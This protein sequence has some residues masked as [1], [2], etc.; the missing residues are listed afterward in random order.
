M[1]ALLLSV[2][3]A[4]ATQVWEEKVEEGGELPGHEATAEGEV[5]EA[6][7]ATTA[8]ESV[9]ELTESFDGPE[10]VETGD[11]MMTKTEAANLL[12]SNFESTNGRVPTEEDLNAVA[13]S[14]VRTNRR[15]FVYGETPIDARDCR[16]V[17]AA[18]VYLKESLPSKPRGFSFYPKESP[19]P[20]ATPS[21]MRPATL[22]KAPT[23]TKKQSRGWAVGPLNEAHIRKLRARFDVEKYNMKG[24]AGDPGWIHRPINPTMRTIKIR[25][26]NGFVCGLGALGVRTFCTPKIREQFQGARGAG[27]M[28]S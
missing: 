23:R 8:T 22:T 14:T 9:I 25:R 24:F 19:G 18:Y 13:W 4:V 21:L 27:R 7:F 28:N 17:L 6:G 10:L 20:D 26:S 1:L 16:P 2:V 15:T 5:A 3:V 12:R 11:H